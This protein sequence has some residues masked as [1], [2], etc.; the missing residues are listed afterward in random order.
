MQGA[1]LINPQSDE[2]GENEVPF[3]N[4]G[5]QIWECMFG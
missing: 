1:N 4:H 2:K 3:E 5:N